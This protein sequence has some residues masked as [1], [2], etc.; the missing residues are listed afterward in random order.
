MSST[1]TKE[2]AEDNNEGRTT[3]RE[4]STANQRRIDRP[5]NAQNTSHTSSTFRYCFNTSTIRGQ[6]LTLPEIIDLVARAGYDAIEPWISEIDAYVEAGGTLYDLKSRIE[7]SGLTVES[8]IGFFEW[9]VDDETK[10]AKALETAARDMDLLAQIGGKR[11]AAPPM[12]ATN[13]S[14]LH[15]LQAAERYRA[16]LEIGDKTG[17]VPQVEVWGFSQSL[18][19][20]GE[21]ALIAIESGHPDAC[22]L[23]DV[24]HLYKGGSPVEGLKL[25]RGAAMHVFHV[26]D[27]P[28]IAPAQIKDEDRVYPGDGTAPLTPI[29][30]SLHEIGFA[31]YLSLELFNA[32]YWQQDAATVV[33]T[34]LQ[35]MRAAVEQS[36]Q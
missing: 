31:G 1:D 32:S 25:V 35:K 7:N 3:R 20:L 6:K 18:N 33:E 30:S 4:Y 34:G 36:S 9:I 2:I 16:L 23:A 28:A 17:V 22:I 26:N 19:R 12:G 5:M 10:R 24:Y 13:V 8:A 15:L 11:I 14:N 21:A 27:Y 29:F